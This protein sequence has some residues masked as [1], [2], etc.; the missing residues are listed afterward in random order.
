MDEATFDQQLTAA[1]TSAV[2]AP[3]QFSA[4]KVVLTQTRDGEQ[5]A[6][7]VSINN[8]DGSTI[9]RYTRDGE[10]QSVR[11]LT[12]RRCYTLNPDT[13]RWER[14]SGGSNAMQY[15]L[16]P[17]SPLATEPGDTFDIS[18]T[19]FTVTEPGQ[20]TVVTVNGPRVTATFTPNGK[21]VVTTITQRPI[22]PVPVTIPG[23]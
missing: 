22:T 2:A 15:A 13:G 18:G 16:N 20:T 10:T 12:P 19:T 7:W 6:R 1:L 9:T 21:N 17:A 11:C 14:S 5:I 4:T 3:G 23:R 8:P